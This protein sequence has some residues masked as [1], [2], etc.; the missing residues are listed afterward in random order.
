M[1]PALER[2]RRRVT[3]WKSTWTILQGLVSKK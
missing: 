3:S 1:T 2:L